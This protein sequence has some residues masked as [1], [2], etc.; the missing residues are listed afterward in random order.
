[1]GCKCVFSLFSVSLALAF[2][3]LASRKHVPAGMNE[4][5]LRRRHVGTHAQ[6]CRHAK[7]L[8]LT[9]AGTAGTRTC[10]HTGGRA[11]L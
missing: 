2:A 6:A 3:L 1:M 9:V 4:P 7:R 11:N 5:K 8:A 10:G